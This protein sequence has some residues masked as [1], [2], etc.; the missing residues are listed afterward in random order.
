MDGKITSYLN[1]LLN[2]AEVTLDELETE[3]YDQKERF[4]SFIPT[5][6]LSL[7]NMNHS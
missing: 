6:I 5:I 3:E 7:L 4:I 2:T 1:T